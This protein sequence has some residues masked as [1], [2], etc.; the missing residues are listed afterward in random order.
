MA[1]RAALASKIQGKHLAFHEAL[2]ASE[3]ELTQDSILNIAAE[4]GL[5]NEQLIKDMQAPSI[6]A[7]INRN[8]ELAR[9]LGINGTPGFIIGTELA[10]GAL[11]LD[12]LKNLVSQTRREKH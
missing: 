5:D 10:P 3:Q 4:V 11:N 1:S 7:I 12:E 2:L 8:R 9:K 6:Q